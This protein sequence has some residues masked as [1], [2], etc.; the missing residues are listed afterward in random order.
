MVTHPHRVHGDS[1][2]LN[3]ERLGKKSLR[4]VAAPCL[5]VIALIAG[6][7]RAERSG[8]ER[9]FPVPQR[10]VAPIV[11]PAY[12]DERT[13][14]EQREAERVIGRLAIRPGTRIA[15]IG[16]GDGYYTV[17]LA[18]RFGSAVTIYAEDVKTDYLARLRE[19]LRGEGYRDV[20]TVLGLPDDPRLPAAAIDVAILAHM[21]HE[22]ENP[23]AFLY[24][25]RAALAPGARVAVVDADRPTQDHGTPPALLR[26]ELGAVGYR[27]VDYLPLV[28]GEI[29]LAVFVPPDSLPPPTQIKPCPG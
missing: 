3:R 7:E 9:G 1:C 4:R 5:L 22:I 15:D 10:P 25:L 6:C 29:Y 11:S 17:R 19:R 14:D 28:P 27:Q 12:H 20:K 21:Y 8:N 18:R 23:Y 26:C 16:A 13:R 2:V 24:R